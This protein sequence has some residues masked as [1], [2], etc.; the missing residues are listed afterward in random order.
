MPN[1]KDEK[2]VYHMTPLKNVPSILVSGLMSRDA[3]ESNGFLDVANQKIIEKR[4]ESSLSK[5]VPFHWVYGC[6]FDHAVYQINNKEKFVYILIDRD[7][8]KKEEWKV[9][10]TH[11]T[12]GGITA[13]PLEYSDGFERIDWG[14]MK[15]NYKNYG[16]YDESNVSDNKE[17]HLTS[18]AECLSP[19]TVPTSK[20]SKI[21]VSD[22]EAL[23]E[24]REA[25]EFLMEANKFFEVLSD[26]DT[27]GAGFYDI[28]PGNGFGVVY[29]EM[30]FNIEVRPDIF[31]HFG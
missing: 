4:S 23:S 26:E 1:Y 17:L 19:T 28:Y 20:I 31:D 24:I 30:N 12:K 21:L 29:A 8:A 7:L 5:Y 15:P 18:M 25:I 27:I 13:A 3:L 9:I 22:K 14:N 10:P 16:D 6:A 11:P 2:Y